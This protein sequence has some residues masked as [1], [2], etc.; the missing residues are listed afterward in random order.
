MAL[1][2]GLSIWLFPDIPLADLDATNF[3]ERLFETVVQ[4]GDSAQLGRNEA[5]VQSGESLSA[6]GPHTTNAVH[7]A[8]HSCVCDAFARYPP[9]P[10]SVLYIIR[11]DECKQK[12]NK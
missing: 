7:G 2:H 1:L 4:G 10:R 8:F 12:R 5:G 9:P 3:E 11:R 6:T